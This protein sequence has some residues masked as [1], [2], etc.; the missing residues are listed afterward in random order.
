MKKFTENIVY[1]KQKDNVIRYIMEIWGEKLDIRNIGI[2]KYF[3]KNIANYSILVNLY[4]QIN[5]NSYYDFNN[6]FVFLNKHNLEYE[7]SNGAQLI[8][9][10]V[11]L[12]DIL[13]DLEFLVKSKK[14]NL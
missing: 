7:L 8:I 1:D 2:T 14:Y 10:C 12:D 6:L 9:I 3:P 5:N 13:N 4:R 11:E